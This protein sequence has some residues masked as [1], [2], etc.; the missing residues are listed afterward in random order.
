MWIPTLARVSVVIF[1]SGETIDEVLRQFRCDIV[2]KIQLPC[3]HEIS[4]PCADIY[5]I[6]DGT[7]P[8]PKCTQPALNKYQYPD[9][10]HQI[11]CLCHQM[12]EFKDDPSRVKPCKEKVSK[13]LSILFFLF[14]YWENCFANINSN[15]NSGLLPSC[16]WAHR[17]SWLCSEAKIPQ[18]RSFL[19]LRSDCRRQTPQMWTQG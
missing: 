7:E 6:F 5:E 19:C 14:F 11:Q 1:S 15:L 8:F 4:L 16:V 13:C 2:E 18:Q 17:Q 3:T 10:L 9:C 12:Q